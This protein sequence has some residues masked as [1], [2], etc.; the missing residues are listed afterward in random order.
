MAVT[1]ENKKRYNDRY[2][3]KQSKIKK[4]SKQLDAALLEME[5][6]P[7]CAE[8]AGI[9]S[10]VCAHTPARRALHAT[11]EKMREELAQVDH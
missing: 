1:S 6:Q 2:R 4:F 3:E 10:S 9:P 5:K 11:A 7:K 8:C